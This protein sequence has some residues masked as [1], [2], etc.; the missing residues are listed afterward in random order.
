MD[1]EIALRTLLSWA[2]QNVNVRAVVLTGSA[3]THEQHPLSDRDVELHVRDTAPLEEDDSWWSELGE[4]LA[5]ERLEN[6]DDEPTR[7]VYYAG[8]KL[9]FT[10]IGANEGCGHYDR[11][12][13][14][15]LDKDGL[16]ETFAIHPIEPQLPQQDSFDECCNWASAAALMSAKAIVRDEPWSVMSRD[17]DLKAELLR[18]IEWDHN[19]RYGTARDVRFLGTRMRQW[20]DSDIQARLLGCWATFGGDSDRALSTTLE[21]FQE[22]AERVAE[23]TN[24]RRFHHVAVRE[25]VDRIL[26][27][28]RDVAE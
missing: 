28:N 16:T 10:L 24:L 22:L 1:Y 12:F 23:G 7:L 13:E 6:G 2:T 17:G 21:L 4:V 3:A 9:D 20:M 25:E 27:T 11:P 26:S 5:V 15:L 18:M 19:I 8:G 14:V